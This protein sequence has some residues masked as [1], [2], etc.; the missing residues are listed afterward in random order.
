M[1]AEK[2]KEVKAR[3]EEIN[4][5]VYSQMMKKEKN[6]YDPEIKLPQCDMQHEIIHKREYSIKVESMYPEK[7]KKR[8][9]NRPSTL[10]NYIINGKDEEAKNYIR[11][12]Y[13]ISMNKL[14][15]QIESDKCEK[16]IRET[17]FQMFKMIDYYVDMIPI[18]LVDE[19]ECM[20]K[21]W[22]AHKRILNKYK[23]RKIKPLDMT[24]EEMFYVYDTYILTKKIILINSTSKED[25]NER[26]AKLNQELKPIY[27]AIRE[28][29]AI[30]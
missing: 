19:T 6:K 11:E 10:E 20:V 15:Q 23:N 29:R 12:Q 26:V 16:T 13:Y 8:R 2:R 24:E 25:Y 4:N 5:E 28:L 22:I 3:I 17:V 27:A 18:A 14:P 21:K 7:N 30:Q 1:N 9:E